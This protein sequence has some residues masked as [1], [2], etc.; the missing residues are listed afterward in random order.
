[1]R[2]KLQNQLKYP[3]MAYIRGAIAIGRIVMKLLIFVALN[4]CLILAESSTSSKDR[5]PNFVVFFVD[6]LGYGDLGFTGAYGYGKRKIR[7][8][9][10]L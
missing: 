6:D 10:M 9:S 1:M 3:K 5:A 8:D 4:H 7:F 2:R